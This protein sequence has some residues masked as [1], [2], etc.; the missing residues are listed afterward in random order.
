MTID[1]V[2]VP[3]D[4]VDEAKTYVRIETDDE[5][6]LIASFLAVAVR[7]GEGFTATQFLQRGV[8]ERMPASSAW[9]RLGVTPVVSITAVNAIPDDG[10]PTLLAVSDYALDIDR[11]GDGWVRVTGPLTTRRIDVTYSAGIAADWGSL[12]DALRHGALRLA[13]HLHAVRDTPDDAG[14][15]A[16][17]TA[18]WRPWRRM[19]LI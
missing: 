4:A 2:I 9:Q 6:A 7:H 14:P 5:D 8:T 13:A 17:V 10:T 3:A 16:A 18:L 12:P 19:R 1:P 11:N 15:P